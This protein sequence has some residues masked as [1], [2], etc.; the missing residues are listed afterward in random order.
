ML[1]QERVLT[2]FVREH[3]VSKDTYLSFGEGVL[4]QRLTTEKCV[5]WSQC[6]CIR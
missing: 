2:N 1:R 5:N 3:F 4:A 6:Y